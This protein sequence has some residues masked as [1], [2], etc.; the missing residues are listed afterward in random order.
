MTL[1]YSHPG[2]SERRR[3]VELLADG[4]HMDTTGS[5][6]NLAGS[7]KILKTLTAHP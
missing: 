1:R 3:A 5:G 7:A 6:G 4:H 2:R